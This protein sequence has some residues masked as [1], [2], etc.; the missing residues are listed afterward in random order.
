MKVDIIRRKLLGIQVC[1]DVTPEQL[2]DENIA[3]EFKFKINSQDLC[4][5]TNGWCLSDR[6]EHLPCRCEEM[7]GRWHYIFIC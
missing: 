2:E 6:E 4:G 1:S 5:T 3:A 7:E